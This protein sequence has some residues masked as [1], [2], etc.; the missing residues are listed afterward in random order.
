M[1]FVQAIQQHEGLP[2]SEYRSD[3]GLV[4]FGEGFTIRIG[5][6]VAVLRLAKHGPDEV[7]PSI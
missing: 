3:Q 7:F 5:P 1:N 2:G 6:E 4:F